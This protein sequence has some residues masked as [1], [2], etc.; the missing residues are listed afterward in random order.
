MRFFFHFHLIL[1]F[2]LNFLGRL[3]IGTPVK[4]MSWACHEKPPENPV[5][6]DN[7]MTYVRGGIL[8][9]HL[10]P[11]EGEKRISLVWDDPAC[12]RLMRT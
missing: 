10:D 7:G 2:F 4:L 3:P 8:K 6:P 5:E 12:P 1:P 9:W 11:G